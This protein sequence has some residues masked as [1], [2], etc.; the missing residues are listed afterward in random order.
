VG[1]DAGVER[2][3]AGG[4]VTAGNPSTHGV[5]LLVVHA[6]GGSR[7]TPCVDGLS[8]NPAQPVSGFA[9]DGCNCAHRPSRRAVG[10]CRAVS[11]LHAR[12]H[13]YRLFHQTGSSTVDTQVLRDDSQ[14]CG[15]INEMSCFSAH[16]SVCR[17]YLPGWQ[18]GS[19]SKST[20][21]GQLHWIHQR[22]RDL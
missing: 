13:R 20:E 2:R 12:R 16:R 14:F 9:R 11:F 5:D 21:S 8:R 4:P 19:R 3:H 1:V 17:A 6:I 15:A 10:F 22:I 18:C 7:A